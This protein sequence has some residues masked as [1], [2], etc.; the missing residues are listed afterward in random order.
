MDLTIHDSGMVT[1]R[2]KCLGPTNTKGTRFT[3]WTITGLN[4][5]KESITINH[6]GYTRN[7][8]MHALAAR[9]LCERLDL[10]GR[11]AAGDLGHGEMVFVFV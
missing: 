1:I 2:T 5:K 8:K 3:A 10:V 9:T 11:L 7:E 6:D 4:G